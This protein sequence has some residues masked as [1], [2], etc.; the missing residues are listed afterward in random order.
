MEDGVVRGM[1]EPLK[2]D[3]WS[4]IACP[5]CYLGTRRLQAGVREYR[6]AGGDRDVVVEY[7][8]YEL[9]PDTPVDFTGSEVDF[10]ARHKGM[11]EGQ[12]R[13]MLGRMTELGAQEGLAYDFDA[14]QHT[15]TLKAHQVLHLAKTHGAQLALVE[16]LFAAY[17]E[18]GRHVGRDEALADLA[19]EVGL[20]RDEVLRAL[21][22]ETYADAVDADLAQARAYGIS[23][24]PFFVVEERY[25]I[26]GAQEPAVFARVL[27]TVTDEQA[28]LAAGS[29]T[30]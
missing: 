22:D 29:D 20:D 14:L 8:S 18:E 24:V 4:D 7:H 21:A 16:R 30:V 26:S 11:D 28:S 19:A 2:I 13:E 17:F 25:G 23:G 10:L 3:V 27:A 6:A 1:T 9:A 12:V 15:R 5:W